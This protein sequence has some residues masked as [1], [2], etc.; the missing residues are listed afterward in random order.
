MYDLWSYGLG[1]A[2]YHHHLE[3]RF[4]ARE[5]AQLPMVNH[6]PAP[7][8]LCDA[9]RLTK[10]RRHRQLCPFRGR[11]NQPK[12][13]REFG[14]VAKRTV[15]H[16]AQVRPATLDFQHPRSE[17]EGRTVT[18]VLAMAA[19]ELRNPVAHLVAAEGGDHSVHLASVSA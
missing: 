1:R 6:D 10:S 12:A 3:L 16:R 15:E 17:L 2:G 9:V 13:V 7:R 18:D 4:G 19:R 11:P 8:T 5:E 14:S